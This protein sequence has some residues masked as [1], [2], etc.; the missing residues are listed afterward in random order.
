MSDETISTESTPATPPGIALRHPFK[1][2]AGKMV[3]QLEMREPKVADLKAAARF[4]GSDAEQEV[5]LLAVL[6]GLVPEDMDNMHLADFRK[7][8]TRF[9]DMVD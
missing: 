7:V 1:T 5:A 6:C 8:Q 4:G 9:R 3:V 2:G